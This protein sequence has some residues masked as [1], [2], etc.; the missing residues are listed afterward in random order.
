MKQY[1]VN[2]NTGKQTQ[3]QIRTLNSSKQH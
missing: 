2:A 3:V 1:N